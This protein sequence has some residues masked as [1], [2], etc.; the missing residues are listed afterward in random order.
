[1]NHTFT[2]YPTFGGEKARRLYHAIRKGGI[3]KIS[4]DGSY[5][6]LFESPPSTIVHDGTIFDA[7]D[8]REL[9]SEALGIR[10]EDVY[11]LDDDEIRDIARRLAGITPTRLADAQEAAH[12]KK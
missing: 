9:A 6:W 3:L 8:F 5:I 7:R 2:D 1:M 11:S 10:P 12:D 4:F